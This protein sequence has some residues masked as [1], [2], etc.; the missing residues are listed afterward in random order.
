MRCTFSVNTLQNL[1]FQHFKD[2]NNI[3][4]DGLSI[5]LDTYSISEHASNLLE[6]VLKKDGAL[7]QGFQAQLKEDPIVLESYFNEL[8]SFLLENTEDEDNAENI[9]K[10]ND[11]SKA[12]FQI[13]EGKVK[14]VES[15]NT[16]NLAPKSSTE[17]SITT[18]D[19]PSISNGEEDQY[20]ERILGDE[21]D[22][23]AGYRSKI[24]GKKVSL[25]QIYDVYFKDF[26]SLDADFK[27][28]FK[29]K[30]YSKWVNTKANGG[31]YN[32]DLVSVSENFFNE[33]KQNAESLDLYKSVTLD[34]FV[35]QPLLKNAYYDFIISREADVLAYEFLPEFQLEDG[36]FKLL[37][38]NSHRKGY[39]IN[40][41]E[42]NGLDQGSSILSL[43]LYNTPRLIMTG[44]NSFVIDQEKPFVTKNDITK[45]SNIFISLDRTNLAGEI[46]RTLDIMPNGNDKNLFA[47]IYYRYYSPDIYKINGVSHKSFIRM[48]EP[49]LTED[50]VN[51][52]STFLVSL[53]D[54]NTVASRDG[55]VYTN[56]N[57]DFELLS[58]LETTYNKIISSNI[59]PTQI[60]SSLEN[61]FNIEAA[62]EPGVFNLSVKINFKEVVTLKLKYT[63]NPKSGVIV[64]LIDDGQDNIK[65]ISINSASRILKS[66]KFPDKLI[67]QRFLE[68]YNDDSVNTST[69]DTSLPQLV[70]NLVFMVAVNSHNLRSDLIQEFPNT[71]FSSLSP[72]F[73]LQKKASAEL[74][75]PPFKHLFAFKQKIGVYD[76]KLYPTSESRTFVNADNNTVHKTGT[77]NTFDAWEHSFNEYRKLKSD[78]VFAN[79]VLLNTSRSG[80]GLLR[81]LRKDG[82]K[83]GEDG[84]SDKN[85]TTREHLRSAMVDFYLKEGAKTNFST[86]VFQFATMSDKASVITGEYSGSFANLGD[87]D[88]RKNTSVGAGMTN[89]EFKLYSYQKDYHN[90]VE[91]IIVSD[92]KNQLNNWLITNPEEVTYT[93][94]DLAAVKPTLVGINDFLTK[95][96]VSKGL[97]ETS[98]LLTENFHYNKQGKIKDVLVEMHKTWNNEDSAKS[99]MRY[100][101]NLYRRE[102][103]DFGFVEKDIKTLLTYEERRIMMDRFGNN[104]SAAFNNFVKAYYY[105][106]QL[107][108]RSTIDMLGGHLYQFKGD[109]SDVKDSSLL[110]LR[111]EL[112]KTKRYTEKQI[113]HLLRMYTLQ[114]TTSSMLLD[115]SKRNAIP[116]SGYQRFLI[117]D[118]TSESKYLNKTSKI[119]LF[120]DVEGIFN[121]LGDL[122]ISKAEVFDGASFIHPLEDERKN[123]GLGRSASSF[124]SKGGA[125]KDIQISRDFRTGVVRYEKRASFPLFS[126]ELLNKSTALQK[127][128]KNLNTSVSFEEPVMFKEKMCYDMHDLWMAAGSLKNP[129]AFREVLEFIHKKRD[130]KGN[131][132]YLNTYI[133][134]LSL[135]SAQKSGSIG[136]NNSEDL[137]NTDKPYI[138]TEISNEYSGEILQSD[139][140]TETS[141]LESHKS[142]TTQ[143][144]SAMSFGGRS[145]LK[146]GETKDSLAILSKSGIDSIM[147][148]IQDLS[149]DILTT[150]I[151]NPN[152]K[153]PSDVDRESLKTILKNNIFNEDQTAIISDALAKLNIYKFDTETLEMSGS[154]FVAYGKELVSESLKHRDSVVLRELV[155]ETKN[156]LET[157]Q[158][159]SMAHSAIMAVV[160]QRCNKIKVKGQELVVAPAHSLIKLYKIPGTNI[161]V[162]REEYIETLDEIEITEQQL[163]NHVGDADPVTIIETLQNGSSTEIEHIGLE[164]K[165]FMTRQKNPEAVY[166]IYAPLVSELNEKG[167]FEDKG[168]DLQWTK[169][170]DKEGQYID[171]QFED[172]S[173]KYPMYAAST[174]IGKKLIL[175][176]DELSSEEKLALI[177]EKRIADSQID[178]L[179]QEDGWE[180]EA[181]EVVMGCMHA[182][183][184][185]L[186]DKV[187]DN[188]IDGDNS[189]EPLKLVDEVTG[190]YRN[191]NISDITGLTQEGDILY[192]K[193]GKYY[194]EKVEGSVEVYTS[195]I[196]SMTKFFT[197]RVLANAAKY[198][199][200]KYQ[201]VTD[202]TLEGLQQMLDAAKT[203]LSN[204]SDAIVE[205]GLKKQINAIEKILTKYQDADLTGE[206]LVASDDLSYYNSQL[207]TIRKRQ[208]DLFVARKVAT[209]PQILDVFISRVP[210]QS[211]QSGAT[212][213][214]KSFVF[215]SRNTIFTPAEILIITG[216]DF[217]IDKVHTLVFSTDE[218]GNMYS[219]ALFINED[220][221]LDYKM[222]NEQLKFT[223]GALIA[224]LEIKGL[225]Q[226]EIRKQIKSVRRRERSVFAE[227]T[228]N[229]LL[230]K[231]LEVYSDPK[232]AMQANTPM[233]MD[234]LKNSIKEQFFTDPNEDATEDLAGS[235]GVLSTSIASILGL[236]YTN[237]VGKDGIGIFATGLKGYSAVYDAYISGLFKN[238]GKEKYSSEYTRLAVNKKGEVDKELTSILKDYV[239]ELDEDDNVL[240]FYKE[241]GER[242]V[243]KNISGISLNENFEEKFTHAWRALSEL[244]SAATDN[245]KELILGR[246]NAD[247]TTSGLLAASLI[248]GIGLEDTMSLF[249]S[250]KLKSVVHDYANHNELT[251]RKPFKSFRAFLQDNWF[252]GG[253]LGYNNLKQEII[254]KH[255]NY[256]GNLVKAKN[257]KILTAEE[258]IGKVE[259]D[260]TKLNFLTNRDSELNK[261]LSVKKV[262]PSSTDAAIIKELN[263]LLANKKIAFNINDLDQQDL[264]DAVKI[265]KNSDS[266][267]FK[268]NV[269]NGAYRGFIQNYINYYNNAFDTQKTFQEAT[270][271]FYDWAQVSENISGVNIGVLGNFLVGSEE[272]HF[273]TTLRSLVDNFIDA[274]ISP[275]MFNAKMAQ[276]KVDLE[277]QVV[278]D[279]EALDRNLKAYL[280]NPI[281]QL[282]NIDKIGKELRIITSFLSINAGNPNSEFDSFNFFNKLVDDL[283]LDVEEISLFIHKAAEYGE[284][285]PYVSGLIEAYE[286]KKIAF[287]PLLVIA[288][289]QHYLAQIQALIFGRKINGA[290]SNQSKNL[291]FL[292]ST[293][294]NRFNDKTKYN[295]IKGLL[296]GDNILQFLNSLNPTANVFGN[297][298]DLAN[299]D[300]RAAF[301]EAFPKIILNKAQT[302]PK[303]LLNKFIQRLFVTRT[304]D[305]RLHKPTGFDYIKSDNLRLLDVSDQASRRLDLNRLP[306]M[307]ETYKDLYEAIFLYSLITNKGMS[308]SNDFGSLF[309]VKASKYYAKFIEFLGDNKYTNS[310]VSK[311]KE[312]DP[313]T[314]SLLTPDSIQ[315]IST[316]AGNASA[317]FIDDDAETDFEAEGSGKKMGKFVHTKNYN[318]PI[319]KARAKKITYP[320]FKSAETKD[321]M[322]WRGDKYVVVSPI[323]HDKIIPNTLDN[324]ESSILEGTN[325][326]WGKPVIIDEAGNMGEVL[327]FN[328]GKENTYTV[329]ISGVKNSAMSA[330][331]LAKLN[332]NMLFDGVNFGRL[333]EADRQKM[334]GLSNEP[335]VKSSTRVRNLTFDNKDA[336]HLKTRPTYQ[337]VAPVNKVTQEEYDYNINEV[338]RYDYIN[339]M[340]VKVIYKGELDSSSSTIMN[341][342]INSRHKD[343]MI[344]KRARMHVVEYKLV[345]QPLTNINSNF[346][347]K[348]DFLTNVDKDILFTKQNSRFILKPEFYSTQQDDVVYFK[349]EGN[350]YKKV[351][352]GTVSEN[353]IKS[354]KDLR[355]KLSRRLSQFESKNVFDEKEELKYVLFEILPVNLLAE[356]TNSYIEYDKLKSEVID[357]KEASFKGSNITI[358]S[359]GS[360]TTRNV[361]DLVNTIVSD[362]ELKALPEVANE[363]ELKPVLEQMRLNNPDLQFGDSLNFAKQ[364]NLISKSEQTFITADLYEA[365]FVSIAENADL[366]KFTKGLVQSSDLSYDEKNKLYRAIEDFSK[367]L[368]QEDIQ[369]INSLLEKPAAEFVNKIT[370]TQFDILKQSLGK[371]LTAENV[372]KAK[373]NQLNLILQGA[374]IVANELY[375]YNPLQSSWLQYNHVEG[376]LLPCAIPS[377]NVENENTTIIGAELSKNNSIAI[378]SLFRKSAKNEIERSKP[379]ELDFDLDDISLSGEFSNIE[380]ISSVDNSFVLKVASNNITHL[381]E[382]SFED[383]EVRANYKRS[384]FHKPENNE[385]NIKVYSDKSLL[386]SFVNP[387]NKALEHYALFEDPS[388][389]EKYAGFKGDEV[390]STYKLK[391]DGEYFILNNLHRVDPIKFAKRDLY[392]GIKTE[393]NQINAELN[394]FHKNEIWPLYSELKYKNYNSI[395]KFKDFN[396]PEALVMYEDLLDLTAEEAVI[397]SAL[398]EKVSIFKKIYKAKIE[399]RN[400]ELLK[401]I[402][403]E[404]PEIQG[405]DVMPIEASDKNKIVFLSDAGLLN[406][407]ARLGLNTNTRGFGDK[408]TNARNYFLPLYTLTDSKFLI[409]GK[410]LV[411]LKNKL[412]EI[413]ELAKI[414]PNNNYYLNTPEDLYGTTNGLSNG[415]ILK[416]I[417][418]ALYLISNESKVT[419]WPANLILPKAAAEFINGEGQGSYYAP[420]INRTQ[421]YRV[422]GR[423]SSASGS[424]VNVT[425]LHQTLTFKTG[426]TIEERLRSYE[427][428]NFTYKLKVWS[429]WI[430]ENQKEFL[431]LAKSIGTKFIY[432]QYYNGEESSPSNGN[433]LSTILNSLFIDTDSIG[434]KIQVVTRSEPGQL[435]DRLN[436]SELRASKKY[437]NLLAQANYSL[438]LDLKLNETTPRLDG[439]K[440]VL[441]ANFIPRNLSQEDKIHI[442]GS[443]LYDYIS[444]AELE[445]NFNNFF[446]GTVEEILDSKAT[447]LVGNE[448]GLDEILSAFIESKK[449]EYSYVKT[450][451]G[452]IH[453]SNF[454]TTETYKHSE[455]PLITTKDKLFNGLVKNSQQ[456]KIDIDEDSEII[457]GLEVVD[458][459]TMTTI[460][461]DLE[462]RNSEASKFSDQLRSDLI[463]EEQFYIKRYISSLALV[464]SKIKAPVFNNIDEFDNFVLSLS[465]SNENDYKTRYDELYNKIYDSSGYLKI[466]D[467]GLLAMAKN[468]NVTNDYLRLFFKDSLLNLN[469]GLYNLLNVSRV[470]VYEK[471]NEYKE[472]IN[473]FVVT[474]ETRQLIE[475]AKDVSYFDLYNFLKLFSESKVFLK[476]NI[477]Y[478]GLA[479]ETLANNNISALKLDDS[480]IITDKSRY[481]ES[482][483]SIRELKEMEQV[484]NTEAMN[485]AKGKLMAANKGIYEFLVRKNIL[486]INP[487]TGNVL[488]SFA[489]DVYNMDL[490]LRS[491][492]NKQIN[493]EFDNIISKIIYY[494]L[495]NAGLDLEENTVKLNLNSTNNRFSFSKLFYNFDQ[496]LENYLFEKADRTAL[497]PLGNTIFDIKVGEVYSYNEYNKVFVYVDNNRNIKGIVD[498]GNIIAFNEGLGW[499]NTADSINLDTS[500][501]D[502]TYNLAKPKNGNAD[503]LQLLDGSFI[504]G[505]FNIS[506]QENGSYIAEELDDTE[507]DGDSYIWVGSNSSWK[508]LYTQDEK[509]SIL[510]VA[511]SDV[512]PGQR[513]SAIYLTGNLVQGL[514]PN[515]KVISTTRI[516]D[517][518]ITYKKDSETGLWNKT[519][520]FKNPKVKFQLTKVILKKGLDNQISAKTVSRNTIE[521]LVEKL[522][523]SLGLDFKIVSRITILNNPQFSKR[524]L[525][526]SGFVI[527]NQAYLNIDNVSLDTPLHEMLGHV[528]LD[529]LRKTDKPLYDYIIAESLKEKSVIEQLLSSEETRDLQGED[530]AEEV[531]SSII[532]LQLQDMAEKSINLN[533]WQKILN[534]LSEF[535]DSKIKPFFGLQREFITVNDSL[536]DIINKVGKDVLLRKGSLFRETCKLSDL[537]N[538]FSNEISQEE[539]INRLKNNNFIKE[540]C[541]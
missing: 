79:N 261:Y 411:T 45:L 346:A 482:V 338:I 513:V 60:D 236:E 226:K 478:D 119:A 449:E 282:L 454:E 43:H 7:S 8:S 494:N 458:D 186:Y 181:A 263:S 283:E 331:V 33:V 82:N 14:L 138:F 241:N 178:D 293:S 143:L 384:E 64:D 322:V 343:E 425:Y 306:G 289:S 116:N 253:E 491:S 224:K 375:V 203:Q 131:L 120:K 233:T 313:K 524:H 267:I 36:I 280:S 252:N 189:G 329:M 132:A 50:A 78:S 327:Y 523:D 51:S 485:L 167:E 110:E 243:I 385:F 466:S 486:K 107:M 108:S 244:L 439:F 18:V 208:L 536:E 473:D 86:V 111:E 394:E 509:T 176:K 234:T 114:S 476:N 172:G 531:F 274:K 521:A 228:K 197:N 268:K 366:V 133:S 40:D 533:F 407:D 484:K 182:R 315:V 184:F 202:I 390:Y 204:E 270:A 340:K 516:E 162:S 519:T 457:N 468:R 323:H 483:N 27:Q 408:V 25:G 194:K 72:E 377:I 431:N 12:L 200:D 156:P 44:N 378:D 160:D 216:S 452:Y 239:Q 66:L 374:K 6:E 38:S 355:G 357:T 527:D 257:V 438:I 302:D 169:Y 388:T 397:Y 177:Q 401:G 150:T 525:R 196:E 105:D 16:T 171:H 534:S 215:D 115:Q 380:E 102:L 54:K 221:K 316:A 89:G 400:N 63:S 246:I 451:D 505:S 369:T 413:I 69:N 88:K 383:A 28:Y 321:I 52:L 65:Q 84:R 74:Y 229:F 447:I 307:G 435:L 159:A 68:Y 342:M 528:F 503:I 192:V 242:Q 284:F 354:E 450:K 432:D 264:I 195:E 326:M 272:Q 37:E 532:G 4:P 427:K 518:S 349:Y 535:F 259:G 510:A 29:H 59:D 35:T 416:A 17:V 210:G 213:R 117:S 364:L 520:A 168:E 373:N 421:P 55:N 175:E 103:R 206:E 211:M 2:T 125:T 429:D 53:Y 23:V 507:E 92:W 440:K 402:S 541:L 410:T 372:D 311:I 502:F 262:G 30:F 3:A 423:S 389:L 334:I 81:L 129:K 469:P 214:V 218:Y 412:N 155:E 19:L 539:I 303:L 158:L 113:N 152:E 273:V 90:Q 419:E 453:F 185:D 492:D 48:N 336:Y 96:P 370:G 540:V 26:P 173:Y 387:E 424:R 398:K 359:T 85:F 317:G 142:L 459:N 57:D 448:G 137:L 339:H 443:S 128:F 493:T 391:L 356:S 94:A 417:S 250:D 456:V 428:N 32:S 123:Y 193:N 249:K 212:A 415:K 460:L 472:M 298:F 140:A 465:K 97:I 335:D 396:R 418:N 506:Q 174:E 91:K 235:T 386:I 290:V 161:K 318:F 501:I 260:I 15:S 58:L 350:F 332:Q 538:L 464:S 98:T 281:R 426:E 422:I 522:N 399:Y 529:Q 362:V 100:Q 285:D 406:S 337:A 512:Q 217:D 441:D 496:P 276:S 455:K 106:H 164:A 121:I 180:S 190:E 232:N 240:I 436:N 231:M 245:A 39:E 367:R 497:E 353:N 31:G 227:A 75:F 219:Y 67:N 278:K 201:R 461:G 345:E 223:V 139:H 376:K 87:L 269:E 255:L 445:A 480:Y 515:A 118:G 371:F 1:L 292:A 277:E 247:A 537:E 404:T 56:S 382:E 467:L 477:L 328:E 166:S 344:Y 157:P 230:E 325:F 104:L 9:E 149:L 495:N 112:E 209:F 499:E 11:L 403:T 130:S 381:T 10:S 481:V 470:D 324:N 24:K 409:E 222:F 526:A 368:S 296:Q 300:G 266:I 508:K 305:N 41:G 183:A 49:D 170:K 498:N 365:N 127:I 297:K 151:N 309:S 198:G 286:K 433:V 13:L 207:N 135:K 444:L 109:L 271:V 47:S 95:Y 154:A 256:T 71:L 500:A 265:I 126:N 165:Y 258:L 333:L 504:K 488:I 134:R 320:V 5:S 395:Q 442:S 517:G 153:L 363:D 463:S 136:L 199:L 295:R 392:L 475:N 462:L 348:L 358:L 420:S 163:F 511:F 237:M 70:A 319:V 312:M 187:G 20:V 205:D 405:T 360:D 145:T 34:Q 124:V 310:T 287:N 21:L 446:H 474:D 179:L 308:G 73:K 77:A 291:E 42:V 288:R 414:N 251:S 238:D 352:K 101:Y 341:N 93:A 188:A 99:Y 220:G 299:I 294:I 146:F 191:V 275:D 304:T 393:L 530:L 347:V 430:E 471:S 122:G 76:Q 434:T 490:N 141:G 254:T 80:F 514:S 248:S 83:I 22:L 330:E 46:K 144:I 314:I 361:Y 225:S 487:Y 148:D 147:E 379:Q 61:K 437:K 351:R 489:G 62:N 479:L 279:K 301:V